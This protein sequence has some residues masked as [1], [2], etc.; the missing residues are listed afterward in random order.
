MGRVIVGLSGKAGAGKD[1]VADL[2]VARHGFRKFAF[3]RS[4]KD[5]CAAVFSFSH[6]QLYGSQQAKNSVDPAWGYSPRQAMQALGDALR[7]ALD[8][9]VWVKSL[10]RQIELS[11]CDRV[12]ICDVR[13]RNEIDWLVQQG[14]VAIR[15][16]RPSSLSG[17]EAAHQSEIALDSFSGWDYI[18]RNES[19]ID[20]LTADVD[21]I[22]KQRKW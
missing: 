2:L 9:D 15:I 8:S 16:E 12:V 4:V 21:N 3:G 22:T 14:G 10:A 20:R 19:S 18:I 6:E 1:T 13:Y 5:A 17:N 7:G 11:G